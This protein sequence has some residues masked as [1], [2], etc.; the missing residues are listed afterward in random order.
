MVNSAASSFEAS[1]PGRPAL[2]TPASRSW[3]LTLLQA[4]GLQLPSRLRICLL[5]FQLPGVPHPDSPDHSP[6]E[7]LGWCGSGPVG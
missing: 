3:V 6:W 7:A 2:E 4:P 5:T 1:R